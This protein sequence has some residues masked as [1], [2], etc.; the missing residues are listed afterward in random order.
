MK[1]EQQWTTDGDNNG[2]ILILFGELSMKSPNVLLDTNVLRCLTRKTFFF[3][4]CLFS[5]HSSPSRHWPLNIL[6]V[7]NKNGNIRLECIL[8]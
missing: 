1:R 8:S 7:P 5:S 3:L 2:T 6:L 4:F